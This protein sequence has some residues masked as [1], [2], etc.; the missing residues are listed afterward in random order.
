VYI[1]TKGVIFN[2]LSRLTSPAVSLSRQ[3]GIA[4]ICELVAKERRRCGMRGNR[5]NE[6]REERE[7]I[8]KNDVATKECVVEGLE[9]PEVDLHVRG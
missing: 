6:R 8:R 2:P 4:T 3:M 7:V 5:A 9:A 1:V